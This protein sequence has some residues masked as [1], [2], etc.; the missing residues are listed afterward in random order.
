M[1]FTV[2]NKTSASNI[3]NFALGSASIVSETFPHH[4]AATLA[5]YLFYDGFNE[6]FDTHLEILGHEF[7]ARGVG[8]QNS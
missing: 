1:T 8:Y 6:Q 2:G 3:L 5:N 7:T 4:I